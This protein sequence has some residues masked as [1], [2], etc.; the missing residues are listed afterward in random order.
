MSDI[1]TQAPYARGLPPGKQPA[2]EF[3]AEEK[4]VIAQCRS[5]SFWYRAL[6]G[7][8]GAGFLTRVMISRGILST[9]S[10]F[11]A[12][13]KIIF[14]GVFGYMIGK[15]SYIFKCQEKIMQLENSELAKALRKRRMP[16]AAPEVGPGGHGPPTPAPAQEPASEFGVPLSGTQISDTNRNN[17]DIDTSNMKNID[18]YETV[19][20]EDQAAEEKPKMTT[21][22]EELRNQNRRNVPTFSSKYS[23]PQPPPPQERAAPA[24]QESS[25]SFE[26]KSAPRRS[27]DTDEA[28]FPLGKPR[29]KNQYGDEW[30]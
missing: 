28:S 2:M 1:G 13:P 23:Q 20:Q 16:G 7:G 18:D 27:R 4:R 10:R 6:P 8:L 3:S 11:G 24:T 30:E 19:A 17:M 25:Q 15:G 12:T 21:T 22:Y 5:D 26:Q 29:K 14:A 9:A